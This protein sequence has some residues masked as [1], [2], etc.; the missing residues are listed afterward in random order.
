M[1]DLTINRFRT[2]RG[3]ILRMQIERLASHLGRPVVILDVG[4]RPDYWGNVGYENISQIRLLNIDEEEFDRVGISKLFV[5]EIGDARN[6][7]DYADKSVDLVHSN[8]VIEHV[9][10]WPDVSAMASELLRVGLSGWVQT[11]AWEFPIE[12]H[13]RLPFLHWFAAPIRRAV[14]RASRDYGTLDIKG[15]RY[16]TD[17]I[18]LLSFGEVKSLFPDEEIFVERYVLPKSY[19][20]RWGPGTSRETMAQTQSA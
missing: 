5:S 12:P 10:A 18:N 20:V 4:G 9:G 15:R 2:A 19:I 6:L 3:R 8:S 16:H 1:H 13:F 14:L 11:P 17:R 7:K